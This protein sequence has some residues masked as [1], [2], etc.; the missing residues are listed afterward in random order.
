[1]AEIESKWPWI[2]NYNNSAKPDINQ[3]VYLFNFKFLFLYVQAL[4]N[5]E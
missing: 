5:C 1:M 4:N 2:R 3:A